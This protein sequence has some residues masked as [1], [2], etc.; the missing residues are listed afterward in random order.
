MIGVKAKALL[1]ATI[2]CLGTV[3]ACSTRS[4][5]SRAIHTYVDAALKALDRGYLAKTT[6]WRTERAKVA[7]TL[8]D[9]ASIKATHPILNRL[10][11]KAGGPHSSFQP[12]KSVK[13]LDKAGAPATKFAVPTVTAHDGIGVLTIPTYLGTSE[14]ANRR[15]DDAAAKAIDAHRAEVTC[16]WIVDVS[17]NLGGTVWPM[18]AAV[19]PLLDD[20]D[21]MSFVDRD[22][23]RAAVTV[24]GTTIHYDGKEVASLGTPTDLNAPVA[25][26]QSKAT[27]SAAEAVVVAFRGQ[28]HARSFGRPTQGFS[29]ANATTRLSDGSRLVVTEAIDAD[30]TGRTY[31]SRIGPDQV[32]P[33]DDPK[34]TAKAVTTWLRSQCG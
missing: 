6:A 13:R 22:R 19:S 26:L 12:P 27:S 29:S 11:K 7:P 17:A 34:A 21:V 15:Y 16:G 5:E 18:L 33:I 9:S 4:A 28:A 25:I 3:T 20:G 23:H 8:Y 10:A 24:D 2:V 30:R 32:T 31:G 1:A 14:T